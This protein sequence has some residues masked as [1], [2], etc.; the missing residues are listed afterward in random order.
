MRPL[1]ECP[2]AE[3]IQ[4]RIDEGRVGFAARTPDGEG[5]FVYVIYDRVEDSRDIS[6]CR[7]QDILRYAGR[8]A[9]A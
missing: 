3:R 4:S 2:L 8:I 6:L 7:R 9:E 5:G 1:S